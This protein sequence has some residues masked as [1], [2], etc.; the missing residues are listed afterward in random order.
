MCYYEK[1]IAIGCGH[2]SNSRVWFCDQ[3]TTE[4]QEVECRRLIYHEEC[5]S[6]TRLWQLQAKEARQPHASERAHQSDASEELG[7]AE[8]RKKRQREKR[9]K[10]KLDRESRDPDPAK[11]IRD[12]EASRRVAA[13]WA[14]KER[15][16][17]SKYWWLETSP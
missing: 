7:M 16:K 10:K 1:I 9:E 17:K 3:A 15:E 12:E 13:V 5:P 4:C 2:S 8:A 11:R 6:C 14:E